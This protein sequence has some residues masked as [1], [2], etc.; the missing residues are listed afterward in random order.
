MTDTVPTP[1]A[2]PEHETKP[3]RDLQPGD[4]IAAGF[5]PGYLQGATVLFT[6]TYQD[7]RSGDW[8]LVAYRLADGKADADQFLADKL[9]PLNEGE[10]EVT[11]APAAEPVEPAE[12]DDCGGPA[13]PHR[14]CCLDR[15]DEVMRRVER[16]AAVGRTVTE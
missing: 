4:R 2:D 9:I 8:T 16:Q 15:P 14:L 5:L 11:V 7:P 6:T 12:C 3:A 13:Q 10:P 1:A